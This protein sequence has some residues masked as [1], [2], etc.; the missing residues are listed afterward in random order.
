M[1]LAYF[2][3]NQWMAWDGNRLYRP[4]MR[5]SQLTIVDNRIGPV[6]RTEIAKMTKQRPVF[7]VTPSSSDEQDTN[8]SELGEQLMR[9]LWKHLFLHELTMK[10]LLWSRITGA[11]FLKCYWDS[12]IGDKRDVLLRPDG[13]LLEDAQGKPV[14]PAAIDHTSLPGVTKKTVAQGD[15]K[16]EV[17]SPFQMFVDPL[18]DTFEE[19]EWVIEESIKSVAYVQRRYNVTVEGDAPANPGLVEARMSNAPEPGSGGY[20]GVKVREYWA[21]SSPDHPNGRRAVWTKDKMLLEDNDPFDACPYVMLSG[22]PI[23]GRLWPTSIVEQL[24]GPQDE[25]NKVKS[26]IAENRNRVGNPTILASKQAVQDPEK[27]LDSMTRPG[28]TYFFDDVGSPN[29]V[30]TFLQPPTL[31]PYVVEEIAR[32]EESIQEISGQHEVSSAQ[33][34]PGV[35]AASAI[36]LLMEADDT[37]L[38]PAMSD[39]E[40]QLGKLGQKLLKLAGKYYTDARTVSIGGD[41]GAWQIFDFRGSQ[42]RGNN[43]VEV[44]AGSAFPQSKAAKQ[45][46]MQDLLTFMVQSGNPPKG[47]ALAQFLKDSQVGGAERLVEQDTLNEGQCNR[48]NVLLAQGQALPINDYDDD[49]AHVANHTDFQKQPHYQSLGSQLKEVVEAHVN[50]HRQRLASQQQAQMQVAMQMQGTPSPEQ[51]QAQGQQQAASSQQDLQGQAQQQQAQLAQAAQQMAVKGVQAGQAQG[52]SQAQAE[53]QMSHAQQ[54][55]EQKL[56]HAQQLHEAKLR[57][58]SQTNQQARSRS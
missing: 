29:T 10:A 46:W 19:A 4:Q 44:Q 41:N 31:P 23:P 55:H 22:I 15:L 52:V 36:N 11:G 49:D 33:V 27:F 38:G 26:Q 57:Q 14:D 47:R 13:K 28:G 48:E 6:V 12:S 30:P 45:A 18:A 20:K 7:T 24:R 50:L 54:L 34:P 16:V 40:F 2:S 58:A 39:Y 3:G 8:A 51:Q 9:Y 43:H 21:K 35:T 17:R 56:A 32:I 53:Q 42:L 5:R 1:N 37:R 25:L